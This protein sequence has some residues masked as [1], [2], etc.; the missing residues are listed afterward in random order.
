M[1]ASDGNCLLVDLLV[2]VEQILGHHVHE[3]RQA[4]G[5][6]SVLVMNCTKRAPSI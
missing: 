3:L 6:S 1:L 4:S 2:T 5:C